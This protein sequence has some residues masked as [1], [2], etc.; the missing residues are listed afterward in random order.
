MGLCGND[1]S[2]RISE[3][4][5]RIDPFAPL[6]LPLCYIDGDLISIGVD[7]IRIARQIAGQCFCSRLYRSTIACWGWISILLPS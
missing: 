5:E 1:S 6:Y 7:E 2:T 3:M 4:L